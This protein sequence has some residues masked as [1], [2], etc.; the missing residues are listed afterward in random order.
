MNALEITLLSPENLGYIRA[1]VAPI[2]RDDAAIDDA[3]QEVCAIVLRKSEQFRGESD[4][5]TWLWR[6]ARNEALGQ[7]RRHKTRRRL[8]EAHGDGLMAR[9]YNTHDRVAARDELKQVLDA[10]ERLPEKYRSVA[11]MALLDGDDTATIA[12]HTGLTIGGVKSRLHRARHMLWVDSG[13]A[14]H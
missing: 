11:R 4:P 13:I 7:L 14:T 10:M 2:L 8:V 9:A 12:D 5:R 6:I 1:I 3:V